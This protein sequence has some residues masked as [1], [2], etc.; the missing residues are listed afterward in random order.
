M[1]SIAMRMCVVYYSCALARFYSRAV[2][3]VRGGAQAP[4][5]LS[6]RPR[7][8]P[9]YMLR[10]LEKYPGQNLH[11]YT[12]V[13]LHPQTTRPKKFQKINWAGNYLKR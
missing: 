5:P 7:P 3:G 11:G 8:P 4:A 10:V 2:P 6:G 9:P 12:V 1:R 13:T